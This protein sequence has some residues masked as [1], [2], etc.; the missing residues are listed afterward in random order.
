MI[1]IGCFC[2]YDFEGYDTFPLSKSIL[3]LENT[4]IEI[5]KRTTVG[6]WGEKTKA[7]LNSTEGIHDTV[8][9]S[10]LTFDDHIVFLQCYTLKKKFPT[11]VLHLIQPR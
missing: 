5:K 10:T 2:S 1:A 11:L 4:T 3:G 9:F 7:S 6:I 8:L